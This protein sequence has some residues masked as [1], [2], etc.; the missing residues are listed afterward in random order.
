MGRLANN[1][2]VRFERARG[3]DKRNHVHCFWLDA[4]DDEPI[5]DLWCCERLNEVDRWDPWTWSKE[6]QIA[7]AYELLED[8]RNQWEHHFLCNC[9]DCDPERYDYIDDW[10][11][12][13]VEEPRY[14][15]EAGYREMEAEHGQFRNLYEIEWDDELE[16]EL[17]ENED[18][19]EHN[20][21]MSETTEQ[22]LE[23]LFREGIAA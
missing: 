4:H 16:C 3:E 5:Y 18:E 10:R 9:R 19:E 23:R 15:R 14:N 8:Q 21:L 12:R 7:Y 6:S 2:R 1:S 17:A 13:L 11:Y 20:L 22:T